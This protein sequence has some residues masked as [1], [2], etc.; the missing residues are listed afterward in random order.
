M[1]VSAVLE[2]LGTPGGNKLKLLAGYADNI[3]SAVFSDF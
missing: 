1:P 3:P 2:V